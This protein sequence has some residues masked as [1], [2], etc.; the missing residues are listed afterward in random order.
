MNGSYARRC[1]AGVSFLLSIGLTG[2]SGF[3]DCGPAPW[4][5]SPPRLHG[6]SPFGSG[7]P[8]RPG[9]PRDPEFYGGSRSGGSGSHGAVR[10]DGVPKH[11]GAVPR[12]RSS[13]THSGLH[14]SERH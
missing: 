9:D 8:R 10:S 12:P 5:G 13:G 4:R 11:R 2:C 3:D 14:G 1:V 6:G 7:S